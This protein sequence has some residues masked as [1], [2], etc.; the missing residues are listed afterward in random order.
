M[1]RPTHN[2]AEVVWA[3]L[4]YDDAPSVSYERVVADLLGRYNISKDHA[5]A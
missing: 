4:R 2:V 1:I 5:L 3:L